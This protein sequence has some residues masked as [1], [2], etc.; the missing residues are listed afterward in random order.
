VRE[1]RGCEVRVK[2]GGFTLLRPNTA[3]MSCCFSFWDGG[4]SIVVILKILA[5]IQIGFL[6]AFVF[7]EHAIVCTPETVCDGRIFEFGLVFSV[8]FSLFGT[9]YVI[10]KL[11]WIRY[12]LLVVF[13]TIGGF[14]ISSFSL[15]VMDMIPFGFFREAGLNFRQSLEWSSGN[16][17]LSYALLVCPLSFVLLTFLELFDHRLRVRAS[18]C[19]ENV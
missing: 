10:P 8:V 9:F 18:S 17:S 7:S 1:A 16:F 2:L 19:L 15:S 5:F 4:V 12:L 11:I 3:A 13:S 14:I 6:S